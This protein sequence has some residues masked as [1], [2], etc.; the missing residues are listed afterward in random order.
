MIRKLLNLVRKIRSEYQRYKSH[1]WGCWWNFRHGFLPKTVA[2]CGITRENYHEFISD[3]DYV[4]GHPYNGMYSSIIDNKLY[5]PLLLHNYKE[6]VP[7]YYFFKDSSGFL[8]L[9]SSDG[10]R[11]GV[12]AVLAKLREVGSL[13]CKR[14]ADS[15]GNGFL[16]I[17]C[18]EEENTEIIYINKKTSTINEAVDVLTSLND[19]II[20]EVIRN[21]PYAAAIAPNS[22]NTIR[23]LLVWDDVKQ[24]FFIPRA[25]HRFGCAGSVVDNLAAGNGILVYMNPE[26]GEFLDEGV[27]SK[28]GE[29]TYVRNLMI[30]PDT[31]VQLTGMYVPN[32]SQIARTCRDMFSSH[33]YLRYLGVDMAVTNEG[34]RIIEINSLTTLATIQQRKG[35]LSDSRIRKVLKH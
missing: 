34:F 10:V 26:T 22:L 5:L 33:S 31:G 24:E 18:T 15:L 13:V 8:P 28:N 1:N 2:V 16:L 32:F 7:Q 3:V 11:V 30:H 35:F 6:Y 19:C 23:L 25:F 27:I 4:K 21:H 17:E 29:D 20:T 9:D 12:D 14:V